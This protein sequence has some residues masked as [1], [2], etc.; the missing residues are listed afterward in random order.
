MHALLI[1][2]AAVAGAVLAPAR[3]G[4]SR[5]AK[6]A[7]KRPH[8]VLLFT[9]EQDGRTLDPEHPYYNV[10]ST[11]A[12]ESLAS[13][14]MNF[15]RTY[16]PAPQCVPGRV[17]TFTSLHTH[18]SLGWNNGQ[19]LA[20]DAK[21][22]KLDGNCVKLYSRETCEGWAKAQAVHVKT[23]LDREL[24]QLGWNVTL[25]GKT[26]VGATVL[27][28]FPNAWA[29]GW[30]GGPSLSILT[31]SA[32][33]RKPTKGTPISLVNWNKP[34]GSFPNDWRTVEKSVEALCRF[35]ELYPDG[36]RVFFYSSVL[37]PHPPL[38]TSQKWLDRVN[39][40]ALAA[41]QPPIGNLSAFHPFDSYMSISKNVAAPSYPAGYVYN[42]TESYFSDVAIA[43]HMHGEVLSALE[44]AGLRDDAWVIFISD[45]GE[46]KMER[47]QMWK[48]S[49]F[50]ASARVPLVIQGPG[51]K[52][53]TVKEYT[54]LLDV[55][56]TIIELAGGTVP[57]GLDGQSLVPFLFDEETAAEYGVTW[58]G[59]RPAPGRP[60]A[61]QYHSNMG[62]T[63]SFML[64]KR[65]DG[66]EMKLI[67]YGNALPWFN[68]SSY[69][70]QLFNITADRWEQTDVSAR[71]PELVASMSAELEAIIP[72]Q[73]AD[74]AAK[75]NDK[76]VFQ[77]YFADDMSTWKIHQKLQRTYKGFTDTD[78][79]KVKLWEATSL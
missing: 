39:A 67:T 12:F 61:S 14:G 51:I 79:Q 65:V 64:V 46:Q 13:T 52:P 77:Q 25:I 11:P 29:D 58:S 6:A 30:H 49:M 43:D 3:A 15:V 8:I 38:H 69:H 4:P 7:A 27:E 36:E 74:L 23:T 59:S 78:M 75:T 57:E 31:R 60:A 56:P 40:S 72:T 42:V 66:A 5:P 33:V 41:V 1:V 28:R 73:A 32:D 21:T 37:T 70:P 76:K 24:E 2:L 47:R 50:E 10:V 20:A 54:S 35:P 68:A 55:M 53:G 62:N 44:R 16:T 19:S 48:N 34:N 22:G 45:H 63:G 71:H 9:D 18:K 17:A 26:D